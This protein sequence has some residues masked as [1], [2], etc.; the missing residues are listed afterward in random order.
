MGGPA[1]FKKTSSSSGYRDPEVLVGLDLGTSKVTVVVAERESPGGEA[2]IIGI[3]QAPSRGIRK[4]LI[5]NIDQT[6]KSLR[7]AIED[8]ETMVGLDLTE[9]TVAFSGSDV[10]SVKTRGMVSLG[11]APRPVMQIDIERVIESAQANVSVPSGKMILHTIPVEYSLDGNSGI[12]DPLGMTAM[13]LDIELESVIVPVAMVQNVRNCVEKAKLEVSGLV[14][15][16]LASALGALTPEESVVGAAVVDIGGG[17]CGAAVFVEGRPKHLAVVS[18]G[19]DHITNDVSTVLKIPINKAEEI[20]KEVDLFSE[21]TLDQ[22]EN[23]EFDHM[24]RNYS[25]S[26]SE[27]TDIV[28]CRVEELFAVLIKNEITEAGVSMLPGGLVITGGGSKSAG[29]DNYLSRIMNMPVRVALPLDSGR[30]PPNR[31]GEEYTCAAGIIRYVLEQ[32]RDPFRFIDN[33][34]DSSIA[35]VPIAPT[36]GLGKMM[37]SVGRGGGRIPFLQSIINLFKELF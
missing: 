5:V 1:L 28:Q 20:K 17:T 16:P 12:D 23:L 26:M 31:N 7:Q 21:T 10:Q 2:Q 15:K 6:V 34:F 9:A 3:G 30:M 36:M 11:R 13:R 25:Y 22:P 35:D 19:G 27:L 24:G 8:A 29:I 4:G 32:E 14:I 37:S 18:V 33:S